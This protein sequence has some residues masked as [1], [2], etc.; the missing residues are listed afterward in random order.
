MSQE[1]GIIQLSQKLYLKSDI[2][3]IHKDESQAKQ[4][5]NAAGESET[6]K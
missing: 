4:L 5:E 2:C 3:W 6:E 1:V